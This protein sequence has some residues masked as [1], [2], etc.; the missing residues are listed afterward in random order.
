MGPAGPGRAPGGGDRGRAARGGK[1]GARA[2]VPRGVRL[3]RWLFGAAVV[4]AGALLALSTLAG[5][6]FPRGPV[7]PYRPPAGIRE[8]FRQLL[9]RDDILPIYE[10]S[11][12]PAARAGLHPAELVIGVEIAGEARAY[13]VGYLNLREMVNDRIGPVPFLVTW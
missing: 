6:L 10:P 2:D 5:L 12:V 4:G 3:L 1:L 9:G 13:P 8:D 7:G 11:F